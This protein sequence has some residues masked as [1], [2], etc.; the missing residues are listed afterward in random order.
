[1]E[2]GDFSLLLF[3]FSDTTFGTPY[4]NE[5]E[6]KENLRITAPPLFAI[7]EK[8]MQANQAEPR[9]RNGGVI[10]TTSLNFKMPEKV[11]L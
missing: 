5:T 1:M 2:A 6:Q 10:R 7:E 4:H 8:L 9:K 11:P 3:L